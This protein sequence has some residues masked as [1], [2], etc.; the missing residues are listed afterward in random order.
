M[1]ETLFLEKIK[2]R[3]IELVGNYEGAYLKTSFKCLTCG[4]EWITSPT[5]I[6]QGSGCPNCPKLK[7][8][9][10]RSKTNKV[11]INHG[12]WLEIDVST[13]KHPKAVM[14]IDAPD[15]EALKMLMYG[16][17]TAFQ[18][19]DIT[20]AMCKVGDRQM[21]V[22]RILIYAP[23]GVDH[24]NHDGLD[25]RRMNLRPANNSENNCNSRLQT[26]RNSS[27]VKGVSRRT[28]PKRG[29]ERWVASIK[30]N[31]KTRVLGVFK[32]KEEAIQARLNAEEE[33][34]G[35]FKY[36]EARE[37]KDAYMGSGI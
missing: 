10:T 1:H 33:Y 19:K 24:I 4:H 11:L 3:Q 36:N 35:D 31:G 9:A 30:K 20:Y 6:S 2:D 29:Y 37:T 16:R 14:K 21:R 32:T 18:P 5:Y 12:E 28:T 25:N 7:S 13:K 17:V 8:L 22:H 27:G 23:E 15:W 34:H 26:H